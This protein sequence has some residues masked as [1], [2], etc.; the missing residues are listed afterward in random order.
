MSDELLHELVELGGSIGHSV[1]LDD[2]MW[3]VS[4]I[5][6]G[7]PRFTF[8]ASTDAEEVRDY[9]D[10]RSRS[11]WWWLNIDDEDIR[12][13][14]PSGRGSTITVLVTDLAGPEPKTVSV[15]GGVGGEATTGEITH[16]FVRDGRVPDVGRWYK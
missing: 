5:G 15:T 10:W 4:P 13:E 12:V 7:S 11:Q 16:V 1:S 2:G 6:K 3:R 9:L 14:H 8:F